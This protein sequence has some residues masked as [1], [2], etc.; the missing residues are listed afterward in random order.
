M[1]LDVDKLRLF[2]DNTVQCIEW[3]FFSWIKNRTAK[4]NCLA[5]FQSIW[6]NFSKQTIFWP[7]FTKTAS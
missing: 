5:D 4:I 6:G 7:D 1:Q 3:P 2:P